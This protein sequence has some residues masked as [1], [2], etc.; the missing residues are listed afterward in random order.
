MSHGLNIYCKTLQQLLFLA[1]EVLIQDDTTVMRSL[2][3]PVS[4]V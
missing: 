3:D 4:T 1:N 2:Y